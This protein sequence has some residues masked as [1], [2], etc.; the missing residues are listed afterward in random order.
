MYEL[1]TDVLKI[2]GVLFLVFE[3]ITLKLY[4]SMDKKEFEKIIR[5][6]YIVLILVLLKSVKELFDIF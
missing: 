6:L 2:I 5:I 1:T 4:R 3:V